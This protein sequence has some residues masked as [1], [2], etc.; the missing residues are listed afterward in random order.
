MNKPL[1][2][3]FTLM[4]VLFTTPAFAYIGPGLGAGTIAVALGIFGS[5]FLALCAIIYYPI[6]RMLR[7]KKQGT[8][9][10]ANH[11]QSEANH[12]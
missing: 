5:I 6:K 8:R 7:R 1:Y 12:D 2:S 3:M 9:S 10:E 4:V 11:E